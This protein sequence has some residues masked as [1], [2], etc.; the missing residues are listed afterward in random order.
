[1]GARSRNSIPV[2]VVESRYVS[3]FFPRFATGLQTVC[4]AC[5][6]VLLPQ[7]QRVDLLLLELPLLQHSHFNVRCGW[8]FGSCF[9]LTAG[10]LIAGCGKKH[11]A[12]GGAI[13]DAQPT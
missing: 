1:M 11:E 5:W 2:T 7:Y 9:S 13:T 6:S 10:L 8:G 4:G 12:G 3:T